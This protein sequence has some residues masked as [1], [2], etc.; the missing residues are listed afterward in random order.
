MRRLGT[1]LSSSLVAL[2]T[3]GFALAVAQ[4]GGNG[5]PPARHAGADRPRRRDVATARW[6]T[7]RGQ[8]E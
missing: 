6:W 8:N 1:G 4:E 3:T 5:Q 7:R 2:C